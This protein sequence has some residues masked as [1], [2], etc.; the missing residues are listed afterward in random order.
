[1]FSFIIQERT[2]PM[3]GIPEP[4]IPLHGEVIIGYSVVSCFMLRILVVFCF[5]NRLIH[6]CGNSCSASTLESFFIHSISGFE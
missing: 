5:Q 6:L 1:M 3:S 2:C 4:Y